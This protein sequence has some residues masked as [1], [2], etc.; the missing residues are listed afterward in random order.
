M[1]TLTLLPISAR[2][3]FQRLAVA[4]ML[5][6]SLL[7]GASVAS[8]ALAA[9][10]LAAEADASWAVETVDG[11]FG[12]GRQNYRYAVEPGD[13][14]ED[15]LVVANNGSAQVD[16]ALYAA[17]AF[18]TD[19]G[20]LDLR[21]REQA[22]TGVGA[23]LGMDVTAI[24][25]DPGESAEIP[26]TLAVPDDAAP[27]DH[28]GGIVTTTAST[29]TGTEPERR[30]AI[31]VQLRVGDT[32]LPGMSVENLSVDHS[33]DP[34]G[35]GLATVTFTLRNTGDTILAA[36]Q[37]ITV[38]GPF[39][40][41]RVA[42]EPVDASPALL[43]E[44]SWTVTVPVRDV[45]PT[46]LLTATVAVTPLYTDAAG[47][48]GPLAVVEHTANGWAIPWLPLLL[49]LGICALVVVGIG[50]ARAGSRLTSSRPPGSPGADELPLGAT[51]SRG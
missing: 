14:L 42:A 17:D 44:E 35:T 1:Q 24:S 46:G 5:G 38:A 13:R 48:T 22:P 50:R 11:A 36:E 21:T 33:G 18:T 28:M 40:A 12:S 19:A 27:G 32:F 16:L 51:A 10:G 26:F 15:A 34:L 20:Q 4:A 30:A 49:V 31:R 47:S 7:G 37:S 3:I 45:P 2:R 6:T 43:P 8:P 9:E 39:D 23:W 41:F 29:S 25:L